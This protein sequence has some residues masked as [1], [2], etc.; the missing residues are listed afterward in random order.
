MNK[1]RIYLILGLATL[2]ILSAFS[3]YLTTAEGQGLASM[4]FLPYVQKSDTGNMQTPYPIETNTP[5]SPFDPYPI[6]TKTPV[7]TIDP[8]PFKI[9]LPGVKR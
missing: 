8:Q 4:L 1:K 7:P 5:S 2:L 3:L 6:E 9:Y